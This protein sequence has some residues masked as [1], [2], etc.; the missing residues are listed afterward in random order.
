MLL[1]FLRGSAPR[2]APQQCPIFPQI[3]HWSE[4]LPLIVADAIKIH[5]RPHVVLP[6]PGSARQIQRCATFY[7]L[8]PASQGLEETSK[9]LFRRNSERSIWIR[10]VSI[11]N[12][13]DSDAR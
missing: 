1:R 5:P 2:T 7:S 3:I 8:R 6:V 4:R 13:N 10:F 12:A 11:A 9:R